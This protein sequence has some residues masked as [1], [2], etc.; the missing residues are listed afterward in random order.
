MLKYLV[1]TLYLGTHL[2]Y[3]TWD[4]VMRNVKPQQSSKLETEGLTCSESEFCSTSYNKHAW[5]EIISMDNNDMYDVW[6]SVNLWFVLREL[7]FVIVMCLWWF[8]KRETFVFDNL[9]PISTMYFF[10]FISPRILFWFTDVI[11]PT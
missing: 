9:Q 10:Q 3:R 6:W 5:D 7:W 2:K 1:S 4:E 8:G 11:L